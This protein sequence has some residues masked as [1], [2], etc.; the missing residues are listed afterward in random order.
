MDLA[1]TIT[2]TA[3]LTSSINIK[4]VFEILPIVHPRNPDGTKFMHPKNTREKIPYFGV[5]NIIVCVKY[6]NKIR[7]IRQN[8]KHMNNVISVDLQVYNKNINLKLAKNN[9]Q[10]TG[11]TSDVMGRN[12]FLVL[13]SHLNMVQRN[14][15]YIRSLSDDK[16]KYTVNWV[17]EK[18]TPVK[19]IKNGVEKLIIPKFDYENVTKEAESNPLVDSHFASFLWQFSDEFESYKDFNDKIVK[20][21]EICF[22]EEDIILED[23]EV[24]I[25]NWKI[26]NS[27]YNYT[28]NEGNELSLIGLSQYLYKKGFSIQF[29][30]WNSRHL[31]VSIPVGED[32]ESVESES[33]SESKTTKSSSSNK[34]KIHRFSIHRGGCSIKQTSPSDSGSAFEARKILLDAIS[35]YEE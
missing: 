10:L 11:A 30:N 20:V 33:T 2:M 25:D 1:S 26:S 32:A 13:C 23:K 14:L 17:L 24:S 27:V 6:I 3:T 29:H 12:S 31:K 19:I 34:I 21:L 5:E 35:E 28:F 8:K 22:G 15:D 7:G 4:S 9:L 18:T 16:K